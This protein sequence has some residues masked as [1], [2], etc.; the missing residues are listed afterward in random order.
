MLLNLA[1]IHQQ[2]MAIHLFHNFIPLNAGKMLEVRVIKEFSLY[3]LKAKP[4]LLLPWLRRS[5]PYIKGV[6]EN[7][8][9][10]QFCLSVHLVS[11]I[12]LIHTY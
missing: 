6:L 1:V 4:V 3:K 11:T 2:E 7:K 12:T 9:F 5:W 8:Q 10:S